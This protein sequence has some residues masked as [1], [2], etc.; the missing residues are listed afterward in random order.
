VVQRWEPYPVGQRLSKSLAQ[1]Q[2]T[3]QMMMDGYAKMK[4]GKKQMD[5]DLKKGG[6]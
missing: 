1:E 5:Q 4:E 2:G 3:L 6:K